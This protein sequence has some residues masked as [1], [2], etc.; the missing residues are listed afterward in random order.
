MS[1]ETRQE[2]QEALKGL[3]MAPTLDFYKKR[4][5]QFPEIQKQG[6]PAHVALLNPE[7]LELTEEE[8]GGL[9]AL[10]PKNARARSILSE[11]ECLPSLWFHESSTGEHI[12]VTTEPQNAISDTAIV[13]SKIEYQNWAEATKTGSIKLFRIPETAASTNVR[14]LVTAQGFI[15]EIAHSIAAVT[16]Y[17]DETLRM[18]NGKTVQG[19]N[20][21]IKFSELTKNLPPISHYSSTYRNTEGKYEHPNAANTL[22]AINE[23]LAETIAAYIVGFSYCEDPKKQLDPF[24]DRPQVREFIENFLNAELVSRA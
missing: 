6:L 17:G 2:E 13:P 24:I 10:F 4:D 11:I 23:E 20:E 8:L 18:P 19:F 15:H 1:K 14:R 22:L 3:D 7:N 9:L 21:I 5:I 16:T 12:E